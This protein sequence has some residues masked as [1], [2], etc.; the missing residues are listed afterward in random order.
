MWGGPA[1]RPSWR[2]RATRMAAV[3]VAGVLLSG[4]WLQIGNGP[5]H[6]YANAGEATLTVGNVATLSQA[7][8]VSTGGSVTEPMVSGNQIYVANAEGTFT[9]CISAR[10][11][12]LDGGTGASLWSTSITSFGGRALLDP[13]L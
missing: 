1:S 12:A 3:L 4:C 13:S 6:R 2:A 10:V 9:C 5:E 11:W 7:W 8:S